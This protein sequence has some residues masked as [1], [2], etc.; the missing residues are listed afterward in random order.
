MSFSNITDSLTLNGTEYIII[1]VSKGVHPILCA[2]F[3][4]PSEF[5]Y[6]PGTNNRRGYAADYEVINDRLFGTKTVYVDGNPVFSEKLPVSVTGA[7]VIAEI[8]HIGRFSALY[9][10]VEYYI[11]F[12]RAFELIF[13]NGSLIKTRDLFSAKKEFEILKNSHRYGS[14]F[15]QA[16]KKKIARKHLKYPYHTVQYTTRESSMSVMNQL[17]ILDDF[18]DYL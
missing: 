2:D 7:F 10:G 16:H 9:R 13:E 1:D 5:Q 18:Y 11:N 4:M 3:I 8:Y 6:N 14:G 17:D 15:L 12:D